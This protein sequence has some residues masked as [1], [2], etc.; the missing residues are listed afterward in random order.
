MVIVLFEFE[1]FFLV[2]YVG[3]RP[4]WPIQCLNKGGF[5]YFYGAVD[6]MGDCMWL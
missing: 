4:C 5:P 6:T 2:S 3:E 1:F